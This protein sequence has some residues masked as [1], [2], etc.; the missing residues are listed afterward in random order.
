M[1]HTIDIS[2]CSLLLALVGCTA[3]VGRGD[4][5]VIIEAEDVIIDGLEPGEGVENIQDGWAVHFD[6]YIVAIGAIHVYFSTDTDIA[7]AATDTYAIDLSAIDPG[8]ESLW[9]L[10]GLENGRWEFRYAT[11]DVGEAT[12]RHESVS[13]EDF[14]IMQ[15]EGLSYL[16]RGTLEQAGGQS[17]PPAILATP[18]EGAVAEGSNAAG[19]PC[20]AAP[21]VSFELAVHVETYYGPCEVD[22]IPGFAITTGGETTV[23]ITV[24]GDHLFFNGFPE[25]DEGGVMRLAQWLADCDLDLDGTVTKAELETVTP[26]DLAE[27]DDRYQLGGSPLTPLQ[28]IWDYVQAQLKTQGHFQ[29][30]GECPIDAADL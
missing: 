2:T 11:V 24:H 6:R 13:E 4:L 9:M 7:V 19:D 27:F 20:Y 10:E 25:S 14:A 29:G 5:R 12:M 28:S 21:T 15:A 17:C 1:K 26:S 3:E 18:P 23:A 30:E 22:G 8:G 16:I